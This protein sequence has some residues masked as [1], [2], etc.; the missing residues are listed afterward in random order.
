[1]YMNMTVGKP[2]VLKKLK[3]ILITAVA[4][5][6]DAKRGERSTREILIGTCVQPDFGEPPWRMGEL[7]S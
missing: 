2:V 3:G 7:V 6:P 4:W 5:N 1:M